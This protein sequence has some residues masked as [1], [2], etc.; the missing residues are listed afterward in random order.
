MIVFRYNVIT[1]LVSWEFGTP[2]FIVFK[3]EKRKGVQPPTKTKRNDFERR[4]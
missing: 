2:A 3:E 4:Y 1:G